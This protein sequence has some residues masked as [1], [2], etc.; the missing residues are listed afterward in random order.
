MGGLGG[1]V[2]AFRMYA[3]RREDICVG[4]TIKDEK[5]TYYKD[6]KPI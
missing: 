6:L 4:C 2:L 5:K 3:V 1:L